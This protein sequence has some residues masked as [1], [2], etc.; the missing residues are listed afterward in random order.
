MT[1][2]NLSPREARELLA[3]YRDAG[4]DALLAEEAVDRMADPAITSSSAGGPAAKQRDEDE[5]PT[6]ASSVPARSPPLPRKEGGNIPAQPAL[7]PPEAAAMAAREAAASA[8]DL[9]A[10]RALLE[11]FQGCGLRATATQLVFADG[12]PQ[13]RV[14][15]VGEAPGYE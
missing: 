15:F 5:T 10:L 9:D 2:M 12:S 6:S 8:K 11:N 7:P 1:P 13:A 3:F 14:M 4:A